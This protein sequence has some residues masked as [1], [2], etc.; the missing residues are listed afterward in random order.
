[1]QWNCKSLRSRNED[2][3][4]ILK[5]ENPG[6]ICLQETKLGNSPYNPG[7][8][9]DAYTMNPRD[10]DR[11][12]G[13]VAIIVSK[14]VQHRSIPLNTA[15]QA[16]AVQVCFERDI[17]ICSIYLPPRSG[18]TM[19]DIQSLARQLPPPF[20]LLG[21]F[22]SH[23]PLWGG[24]TSD[25][26]G[27][28]IDDFIQNNDLSIFNDGAMTFH[29]IYNNV[30]S[31]I[32][33][34]LCSPEIHLD[35][36]WSVDE[37]LHGSDHFP[38]HLRYARNIPT[39][40]IIKWKEKEAD[41]AKF[42]EDFDLSQDFESF[43]SHIDAYDYFTSATLKSAE[44]SIPKTKG[45]PRRPAVPWWD[46][47]CGNLRKITRKCYRRYKSNPSQITKTIYQRAEA[48]K[49]KYFRKVKKESWLYY[50]NGINSKTPQRLVW[51]KVRK[52][53]GKFVPSPNP[54][55]KVNDT[56]VTKPEDV[57]ERFGS[58]FSEI[59]SSNNY[60]PQFNNIRNSTVHL[61]FEPSDR[62]AYNAK[63]SLRELRE[64]LS[65]C[66]DTS[67]GGDNI[68]YGMLKHLPD[69]AKSFLLKILNKVWETG[70][71]PPSWKIAIVV[72]IKKPNKDPYNPTSY[73]PISL[74]SCVCKLFEKMVNSRLMWYLENENLLSGV[75][76]GFRKNRS[77]L[78][79]LLRLSTQI[80][81]G[82]SNR[83]QTVGVFFDLEKAYDTTWRYG[84]IKQLYNK[85]IRGNMIRFI[86]SF[87]TD[88]LIKVRV[89]NKLSSSYE[90]E[91]GVPQGS[92]LSVTCFAIA[93][94]SIVESVAL[95]VRGSLFVDDFAIYVTTYDAVS[96]CNYLQRSI[97]AI[98][99]WADDHGFKF[100]TSKTVAVRFT[101]CTRRE[102]VPHLKL[103]DSLIPYEKEVKFLGMIFDSKLTWGSHIDSLKIKVKKSLNILKVVSSF[104]WGADKKSLLR[105]YNSLCRSKLEYGSQ[106]YSSACVSKLKE[107]DVVHNAGL[108]ICSGAFKTS[109]VESL[110][111]DNEELPLD[112]RREELGLRYFMKLK[113]LPDNP[114]SSV[115]RQCDPRKF[116][117]TRASK[118]FTVR[119]STSDDNRD[120]INQ[121]IK[122]KHSLEYPPWLIPQVEVCQKCV[123]KKSLSDD[124]IKARFLDHD[125]DH[126][127]SIKLYTDGSK[128]LNGVGCAVVVGDQSYAC[129]LSDNASIFTAELTALSK[130]LSLVNASPGNKFII[131]S[132][133]YS[134]LMAIKVYN[135]QHPVVQ[136]IQEW[137]FR[138]SIRYKYVQFC[139]VPAHVGIQG[140][141]QADREARN[142][143]LEN[144]VNFHHIPSS[145]MKWCIRSHVRDKWQARWSSPLLANNKKYKKVRESVK[146]WPSSFNS[147]R[148]VEVVLSRLRIGHTFLTHQYL[149]E[150]GSAPVCARC[151]ITLSVEH[152][153][154]HCPLYD[155]VRRRMG[156]GGKPISVLL[157]DDIEVTKVIQ[158][159]KE[160]GLFLKI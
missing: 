4:V 97:N 106:I 17:T 76:F 10:G 157:G 2:L 123:A 137:L 94:D 59:S 48:K 53:S 82:F 6:V 160:S 153:L 104:S 69:Q 33:L 83:L 93:I 47:N 89:G 9:Y 73:R 45:K 140:N 74:T 41:W 54:I 51:Q 21:D 120:I 96:A 24:N 25:V 8:N 113:G 127:D 101:R 91:E 56:L 122:T 50:I 55:L 118:P 34:S 28:I 52:L 159:L 79:P 126:S 145:D 95:P 150:G 65:S 39:D 58:H 143:I 38:I 134:A 36:N 84:I 78:D 108:R 155:A 1:M 102:T 35:F 115:I 81:Q 18:I 27:R 22:N 136:E 105:L 7:L 119:I 44:T 109:P 80:Q 23:N 149:L 31:A 158:F 107:L 12:H 99:K 40:S 75:Q 43:E 86:E 98:S 71:M 64:A 42:Q 30:L 32:D 141:E 112:L 100:S 132:D 144:N 90:L 92:V 57:A 114:A 13:G 46:K 16:V 19:N 14:M 62:E 152:I 5:E 103:K 26:E 129:R 68:T 139:W 148:K 130:S 117:S 11:A 111:V 37:F 77:T 156:F 70:I 72:P 116:E 128:T 67:P 60:S 29:D 124:E 142:V 147:N 87:L 121:K 151:D 138:L 3:K 15:L 110:Y 154:V 133:S 20:V 135:P 63:F 88:R 61:T 125:R 146:H 66:D 131:Y 85:G 49:K